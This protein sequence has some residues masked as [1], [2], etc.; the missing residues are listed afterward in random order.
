MQRK[1]TAIMAAD[2]VGYSRLMELDEA[3]TL[4]RLQANRREIV[5]P[6]I[7][8]HGGRV[9]KLMGDGSLIEFGSVVSAVACAVEIQG[10]MASTDADQPA[11]R[12][13]RYRIGLNLGDVM[14]EGDDIYGDG[15][16]V[17]ARLQELAPPGGIA[18][19][20]PVKDQVSGK[21][22]LALDD[23]GDHSLKNIVRPIRV[24]AVRTDGLSSSAAPLSIDAEKPDVGKRVALCVLPF[25]NMSGDPEQDYFSDGITEDIITDLSKVASLFVVSRNTAF[26]FKGKSPNLA[27]IA[28]QLSVKYVLEGSVRKAGGRVR[29]TAQLIEGATDG[30]VWAER[31]DRTLDDIFALQDEISAAIVSA[32]RVKLL[33]EEKE[34][35]ERHGTNNAEAYQILLMAR[36]YRYSGSAADIGIALRLAQRVVEIDPSYAEAWALIATSQIA[37]HENAGLEQNGLA[38]AER[39]LELDS[40]LAAAHAAKGRV[41]AGLGR[42]DEALAAHAESLHLDPESYD[43]HY[44]YGRTCTELGRAEL[45]VR[46][47]EKAAALSESDCTALGLVSQSY[48]AL[49]RDEE[50]RDASRRALTRIEK[51]IA[52][53]PDDTNALFLGA[54]I[55]AEL[56][57]A[58]R[59]REWAA[60]VSLL[61]PDDALGHYNL[62]CTFAL[63]GDQERAVDFLER[64]FA[65]K[66]PQFVVWVKNDSDLDSLRNHPRYQALIQLLEAKLAEPESQST[67]ET[68][69]QPSG[70]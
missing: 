53:R 37:L 38:A 57:H 7:A 6:R 29:I 66:H 44:L 47:M 64:T 27:Q 45:A 2:V 50:A 13:I 19:S 54:A 49:H 60:R 25:T 39:A 10:A 15:V 42:Y 68:G 18:L 34:A 26:S 16:N 22:T 32:L 56:G 21:I 62:C 65:S 55:L 23:L 1:L 61:A 12:R 51:A 17:A 11:D 69:A 36:H 33:P 3:G 40:N 28:R 20:A 31:Y 59:A 43:A 30:H 58:D 4:L 70:V 5:M 67:S 8:S 9:V 35:I 14:V 52:R 46:H 41:L 63:L 24:F 48:R